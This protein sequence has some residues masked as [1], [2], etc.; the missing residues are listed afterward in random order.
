MAACAGVAAGHASHPFITTVE[1]YLQRTPDPQP[2]QHMMP[3]VVNVL[4]YLTARL[5][6]VAPNDAGAATAATNLCQGADMALSVM[7][8]LKP[9]M[10]Y[11]WHRTESLMHA[12][13]LLLM[14]KTLQHPTDVD[15]HAC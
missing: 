11:L 14:K 13:L 12:F 4:P 6:A 10:M 1:Q 15:A 9:G 5:H 2:Q 3:E 8:P 7:H